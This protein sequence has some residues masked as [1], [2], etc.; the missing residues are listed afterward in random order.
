MK[1]VLTK[2]HDKLGMNG[3]VVDVS[4]G[5][6]RNFLLPQQLALVATP[7][8]EKHFEERKKAIVKKEAAILARA[9]EL[10]EKL[11]S[12]SLTIS[13]RVGEEGKLYGTVTSKEVV[14]ALAGQAQ[15]EVDKKQVE[16]RQAIRYVG[17][18]AV[19]VKLHPKVVAAVK[20]Q[21]VAQE[22]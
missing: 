18:H 8:V 9:Q 21:V 7:N 13:E 17:E 22:G 3:S 10:A 19:H 14:Q 20:V 2:N 16:I 12:L 1:V 6:A 15:I 11:E 4:E 5:Y